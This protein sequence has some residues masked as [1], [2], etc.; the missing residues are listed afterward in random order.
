MRARLALLAVGLVVLT[1]LGAR[2]LA[3]PDRINP[4]RTAVAAIPAPVLGAYLVVKLT[5]GG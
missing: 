4:V 3:H 5:R 1:P 2:A